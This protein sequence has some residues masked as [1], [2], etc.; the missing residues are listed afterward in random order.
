MSAGESTSSNRRRRTGRQ[1][2]ASTDAARAAL[3]SRETTSRRSD[4]GN[5]A[6]PLEYDES[7]FPIER[8]PSNFADRVRRLIFG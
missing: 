8:A 3:R 7:G 6:R 2:A 4:A 1:G 5:Y